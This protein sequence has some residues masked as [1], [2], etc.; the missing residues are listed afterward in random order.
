MTSIGRQTKALLKKELLIV[1][2]SL[3]TAI[4]TVVFPIVALLLFSL[5]N[6]GGDTHAEKFTGQSVYQ[7][8]F[9]DVLAPRRFLDSPVYPTDTQIPYSPT[10]IPFEWEAHQERIWWAP[11]TDSTASSVMKVAAAMKGI[12]ASELRGFA[13]DDDLKTAYQEAR[14]GSFFAGIIFDSTDP[15]LFAYEILINGTYAPN[16]EADKQIVVIDDTNHALV[17]DYGKYIDTGFV[18]IQRMLDEAI[19]KVFNTNNITN[20]PSLNAIQAF[21]RPSV[22]AAEAPWVFKWLPGNVERLSALKTVLSIIPWFASMRGGEITAGLD[23]RGR[24]VGLTWSNAWEYDFGY[25]LIAQACGILVLLG[26]A[27]LRFHPSRCCRS[28]VV[29]DCDEPTTINDD[30]VAEDTIMERP[31]IRVTGLTK[32][33]RRQDKSVL[34]AVNQLSLKVDKGEILGLLGHNG[35]GKTTAIRMLCREL[36]PDDGVV[37]FIT[38]KGD[39]DVAPVLGVCLQQ[40]ILFPEL[41]AKEHLQTFALLRGSPSPD[42]EEVRNMMA[43]VGLDNAEID[44]CVSSYSGG[45]KRK[46][47]LAISL[48]GDPDYLL[49]DEP[50]A[51]VDPYSRRSLW[52]VLLRLAHDEGKTIIMTTHFMDE[53]DMLSNHIAIMRGGR[54]VAYGTSLFLKYNIA[55]LAATNA[56]VTAGYTLLLLVRLVEL[57]NSIVVQRRILGSSKKDRDEVMRKLKNIIPGI[58]GSSVKDEQVS[59]NLPLGAEMFYADVL[60]VLNSTGAPDVAMSL[61]S[62]EDVFLATSDEKERRFNMALSGDNEAIE[63]P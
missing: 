3:P 4:I 53:A 47:S 56:G 1:R 15:T 26:I 60:D 57:P 30:C 28:K 35:A 6:I 59:V 12:D 32:R 43:N 34:T 9:E 37:D 61:T 20:I 44:E 10:W 2:K 52:D 48:L 49:L 5:P 33:F 13:S 25:L 62:L 24:R 7:P 42:D 41:S 8:P 63:G 19:V 39:I 16:S 14:P 55:R 11:T 22:Q 36:E 46:L 50:S 38:A 51:G 17:L 58:K 45:M 27:E 54:L 29:Q 21:P 18:A 31:A 23:L 40:D